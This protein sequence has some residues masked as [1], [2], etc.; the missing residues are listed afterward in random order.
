MIFMP[1]TP[2]I[3]AFQNISIVS[4][5]KQFIRFIIC[6][7]LAALYSCGPIREAVVPDPSRHVLHETLAGMKQNETV[8]DFL[9]TRFSGTANIDGVDY[10]VGGTIRIKNDSAIFVSVSPLLGIEIARLLITPDTVKMVN[11]LD[12]TFYAGNMEILNRMFNTHLDYYMLQALLV[13]N[14]FSHFSSSGFSVSGHNGD[15]ILLSENR[16][17]EN[18]PDN[19]RFQHRLLLS[20]E[21]YR[22]QENLLY[23]AS[24]Q[25]SLQVKYDGFSRVD[26]QLVPQ[27]L[28]MIFSGTGGQAGLR[29]RFNRTVFNQERAIVFTIPGHYRQIHL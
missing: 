19:H 6:V 21:T 15:I 25:R 18:S 4:L 1:A 22:I 23:E 10:S 24:S 26:G 27:E 14:D 7:V 2:K 9:N 17:P 11:R 3:A 8:F 5:S 20:S 29:L 16:Y 12:N 28:S 13:G